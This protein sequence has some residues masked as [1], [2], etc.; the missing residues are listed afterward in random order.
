MLKFKT[1]NKSVDIVP[2]VG[3][4]FR[5]PDT[6]K[7]F[8]GGNYK[9]FEELEHHVQNY[10]TQNELPP[11]ENF[12]ECWEHYICTNFPSTNQMCCPVESSVSRNFMQYISGGLAYLKL[13]TQKEE[14]KFVSSEE[15]QRRADVCLNCKFNVKNYGHSFAHYYTDKMMSRSV[16]SRRVKNWQNL[17]TCKCCSCI[18]NSKVWFS[19]KVVGGSLLRDDI[20]QMKEA[21]DYS[22][23]HIKCWQLEE[24]DKLNGK[25]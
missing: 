3:F 5:D 10:R 6:G 25:G 18:L 12:R 17:F 15:A 14:D 20:E 21:T 11:I 24:R 2:S 13:A 16:G 22:G 7:E 9:T 19:G 23:N 4:T 8:R 1:L